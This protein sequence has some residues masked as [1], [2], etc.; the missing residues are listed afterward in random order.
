MEQGFCV[1][2]MLLYANRYSMKDEDGVLREGI[3]ASYIMDEQLNPQS[4]PDTGEK[5]FR[6]AKGAIPLECWNKVKE[7]P[8]Y[9]NGSFRMKIG[10]DGKPVLTL[11]DLEFDSL[12]TV[13]PVKDTAV[14]DT[15]KGSN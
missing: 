4:N 5:G 7:V 2:F 9:Y 15:K 12:I 6:P 11:Q 8:A 3:T 1:K 14:T 10:S 13:A